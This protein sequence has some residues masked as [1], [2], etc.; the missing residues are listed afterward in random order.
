M[1]SRRQWPGEA[2]AAPRRLVGH[3]PPYVGYGWVHFRLF[4]A[5]HRRP[6]GLADV[7]QGPAGS[8]SAIRV[9]RDGFIRRWRFAMSP[10]RRPIILR[11]PRPIGIGISGGVGGDEFGRCRRI[12]PGPPPILRSANGPYFRDIVTAKDS[13]S[14]QFQWAIYVHISELHPRWL[15]MARKMRPLSAA[16]H[17]ARF[18]Q[19]G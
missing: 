19:M 8:P 1:I 18:G 2:R 14:R 10:P 13:P 16:P 5:H 6:Q 15:K 3:L 11:Q 17:Q 4:Y 7:A 9:R 12:S